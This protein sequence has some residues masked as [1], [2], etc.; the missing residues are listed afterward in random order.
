MAIT[1]VT[2]LTE[3]ELNRIRSLIGESFVTNELFHNWGSLEE[4]RDDVMR[5]MSI[6]TDFVYEAGELYSNEDG[7]GFIGLEDSAHAA[8]WPQIR[9]LC[10]MLVRIRFSKIKSLM[11]FIKQIEGSNAKYA[12]RR[13]IDALMVCVDKDHQGKGVAT[14]LIN[15]AKDMAKKEGVPLLFDTDME[16]YANMYRHFGCELYNTVTADNGV[17]R[18]SLCY[19]GE[20]DG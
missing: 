4:R 8:Q 1:K 15:F 2:G 9:M 3:E 13:H 18:Y 19:I 11:K 6:Y 16:A 5:Y 7:T 12:K 17:T 10:R 20:G 14:E